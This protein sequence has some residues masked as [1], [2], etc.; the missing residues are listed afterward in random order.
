[1]RK[2]IGKKKKAKVLKSTKDKR[3]ER[4]VYII[5][6]FIFLLAI[7]T[8]YKLSKGDGV[9]KIYENKELNK[10]EK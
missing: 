6:A 8:T 4:I 7:L 2:K 5:I 1:M 3:T 10:K 9:I